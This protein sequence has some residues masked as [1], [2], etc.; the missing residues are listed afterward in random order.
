MKN[1]VN[2]RNNIVNVGGQLV[3]FAYLR[4]FFSPFHGL[5]RSEGGHWNVMESPKNIDFAL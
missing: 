4:I 2:I 1:Q 5:N 3:Q